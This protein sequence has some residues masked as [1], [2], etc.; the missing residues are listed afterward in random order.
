MQ[1]TVTESGIERTVVGF[2]RLEGVAKDLRPVWPEIQ[3]YYHDTEMMQFASEG[4]QGKAGRWKPLSERYGKWK[5]AHYP[6]KPILELTG[7]LW[8][9]LTGG[10]GAETQMAPLR[11]VEESTVPYAIYHARGTEKMP[12]RP[13]V[14]LTAQQQREIGAIV[15]RH[16]QKDIW[17]A[18]AGATK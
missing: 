8:K 3:R 4:G 13:P 16:V 1:I 7:R 14:S 5:Q 2:R 12:S 15:G 11:Y 10:P 6:G 9:S 18:F 17:K